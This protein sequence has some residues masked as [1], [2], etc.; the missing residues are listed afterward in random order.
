MYS[1]IKLELIKNFLNNY[2]INY[3]LLSLDIQALIVVLSNILSIL[4]FFVCF[5]IT[6]R[7]LAKFL[8]IILG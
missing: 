3:D 8:D 4:F 5:Y 1:I 2:S 7:V 6:Y